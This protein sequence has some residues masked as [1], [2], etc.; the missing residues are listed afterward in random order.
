MVGRRELMLNGEAGSL[1]V[2]TIAH[3]GPPR[4]GTEEEEKPKP[5]HTSPPQNRSGFILDL[6][7]AHT[8]PP[9]NLTNSVF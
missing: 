1:M 5:G 4:G 3:G 7:S 9:Q 2:V 6:Y 8:S